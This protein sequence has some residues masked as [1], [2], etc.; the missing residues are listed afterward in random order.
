MKIKYLYM[1]ILLSAVSFQACNDGYDGYD[2]V[3]VSGTLTNNPMIALTVDENFPKEVDLTVA[4]S[5]IVSS[6]TTVEMRVDPT[7]ISNYNKKYSTNYYPLPKECYI[8]S[9]PTVVIENG[10]YATTAPVKLSIISTNGVV[11]GRKY[12]VPVSITKVSNGVRVIEASRTVYVAINQVIVTAA[13]DL[14]GSKNIKI[15]FSREPLQELKYD[16]MRLEGFSFEARVFMYGYGSFNTIMGLEENIILR[17]STYNNAG[18]KLEFCG[19][20]MAIIGSV[21][22]FPLKAWTHVAVTYDANTTIASLYVNGESV[23]SMAVVRKGKYVTL[24]GA[25]EGSGWILDFPFRIGYSAGGRAINAAMSEARVWAKALTPADIKN[26][27]CAVD[28]KTE[29]LLGYWKFNDNTTVTKFE[30]LTGNG[31]YAEP[32]NG[33]GWVQGVRC[34]E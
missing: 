4:S 3:Y 30:D 11:E 19:D 33:F 9:H 13:I 29:G 18:G 2:G 14:S 25:Y 28:P 12:M 21:Q 7:L 17:T 32:V 23:S 26:N 22:P 1:C 24:K 20:G 10:D 6:N 27:M 31:F 8:L 15:D 5:A 34:P 16:P